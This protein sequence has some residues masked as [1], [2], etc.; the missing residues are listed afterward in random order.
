MKSTESSGFILSR[1]GITWINLYDSRKSNPEPDASDMSRLKLATRFFS[2]LN[3]AGKNIRDITGTDT[4]LCDTT[5]WQQFSY[6]Y[7]RYTNTYIPM[8]EKNPTKPQN[9]YFGFMA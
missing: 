1:T 4:D 7:Y 2:F 5:A 6:I 8:E 3:C 9:V